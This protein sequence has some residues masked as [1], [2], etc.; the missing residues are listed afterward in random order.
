V[1]RHTAPGGSNWV[2]RRGRALTALAL[3]CGALALSAC[4][5]DEETTATGT[6]DAAEVETTTVPES[7]AP[8]P[9][10]PE[11]EPSGGISSDQPTDPDPEDVA[12]EDTEGGAGDEANDPIDDSG[13]TSGGSGGGSGG[14]GG[15]G[16]GGVGG[17]EAFEQF[18]EENP[19]ACE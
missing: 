13:G 15:S 6:T 14:G 7:V 2:G 19:R 17:K 18:C 1:T 4:G 12:P 16:S 11:S 3:A 5:D 10:G 8:P 9:A